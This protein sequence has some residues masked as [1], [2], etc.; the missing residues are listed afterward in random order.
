MM[1]LTIAVVASWVVLLVLVVVVAAVVRQIGLIHMR[2]PPAGARMSHSGPSIGELAPAIAHQDIEGHQVSLGSERGR[3]TLLTFISSGCGACDEV[4]P[5]LQSLSVSERRATDFLLISD[6]PDTA[7]FDFRQRHGLVHIPAVADQELREAYGIMGFPHAVL[8][9]RENRVV[10][11]GMV[12]NL[13]HFESLFRAVETKFP[14][15]EVFMDSA[16]IAEPRV[17]GGMLRE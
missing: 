1:F 3:Q 5:A 16:Q 11:K 14:S 10:S 9:D 12:N 15:I 8:V 7:L 4:A 13:E 2:I 17:E 6:G